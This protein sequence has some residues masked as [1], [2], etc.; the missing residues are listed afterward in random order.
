[1]RNIYIAE[2]TEDGGVYRYQMT[3]DGN[4]TFCEKTAMPKPMYLAKQNGKLYV[5]LEKGAEENHSTLRIYQLDEEGAVTGLL[6]EESSGGV[7]A[8]H[9]CVIEDET[10]YAVNYV[11]GSVT[12][13]SDKVITH[14]GVCGPQKP[15]QNTPHT[16]YVGQTPDGAYFAVTDLGLDRIYIYDKELQEVS[17]VKAPAG[18][19]PRHLIF[20]EDGKTCFCVNELNST[21]SAYDYADGT[22]TL[23]DTVSI[24][25]EG[26][27]ELNTAA[28][29]RLHNGLI[30]ASNRGHQS[31]ACLS[32]E[33]KKLKLLSLTD[34]GGAGPRD[35]D[36]FDD[37]LIC[38]NE[39]SNN[40]TFF[41]VDGANLEKLPQELKL[42][43]ALCVIS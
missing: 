17:S 22:L 34:C 41:R 11:S 9:L 3:E 39:N 27:S 8:C 30:Y 29:I 20:S 37:I 21:V 4:V 33:N 36:I 5:L 18:C 16:H 1:M 13:F 19:G 42:N 15:R 26:F 31:I 25:P 40:V 43:G 24:L 23:G 6:S 10:V 7:C 28:A 38:T 32:Y 12:K 2:C 35:F 14:D